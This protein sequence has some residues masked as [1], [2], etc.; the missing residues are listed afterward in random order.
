[1]AGSWE[2]WVA[3][4]SLFIASCK[5]IFNLVE[6]IFEYNVHN[7]TS[8]FIWYKNIETIFTLKD[9]KRFCLQQIERLENYSSE[10]NEGCTEGDYKFYNSIEYIEKRADNNIFPYFRGNEVIIYVILVV[11]FLIIKIAF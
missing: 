1:M 9:E 5:S 6:K 11:I 7:E 8:A 4:I 10:I 3:V 2:I